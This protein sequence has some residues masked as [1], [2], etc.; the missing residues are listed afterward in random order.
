MKRVLVSGL[1]MVGVSVGFVGESEA[2][3]YAPGYESFDTTDFLPG[4]GRIERLGGPKVE[5]PKGK[6]VFPKTLD[7]KLVRA[8]PASVPE[9]WDMC[10]GVSSVVFKVSRHE[11]YAVE[12][13][14]VEGDGDAW[15]PVFPVQ[16]IDGEIRLTRRVDIYEPQ[17]AVNVV[18][19]AWW[20]DRW[21]RR[22]KQSRRIK[23]HIPAVKEFLE[24]A[25]PDV[26]EEKT[27]PANWVELR[28]D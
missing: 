4:H 25:V 13:E 2:C 19:R 17:P 14:V 16:P 12:F 1:L 21:G 10:S 5:E 28:E 6:A 3:R 27:R 20:V 18:L 8:E 24:K 9:K 26:V 15:L 22:S 11:G 23:I 7:L